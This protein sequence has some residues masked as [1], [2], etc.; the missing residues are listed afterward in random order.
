MYVHP[1]GR[2]ELPASAAPLVCFGLIDV[3]LKK[4]PGLLKR[5]GFFDGSGF[6]KRDY[7]L[8]GSVSCIKPVIISFLLKQFI[9]CS[10]LNYSS[11]IQYHYAV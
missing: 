9:V 6:F 2:S 4:S 7:C 8:S 10:T 11:V 3:P 5:P 1:A